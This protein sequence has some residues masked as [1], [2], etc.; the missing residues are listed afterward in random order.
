MWTGNYTQDGTKGLIAEGGTARKEMV[1]KL[2]QSVGGNLEVFYYAFGSDDLVI[3][4]EV[5][6]NATGASIAMTV[7]ASGAANGRVTILLTPEEI[8]A[9]A[10][11]SPA[12]KPP[13][14]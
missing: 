5:P 14:A 10:K 8:D 1:E 2:V 11:I 7:A 6:D 3:I 4:G 9:A 13:S 12:Y